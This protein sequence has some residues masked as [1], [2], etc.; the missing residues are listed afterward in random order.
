MGANNIAASLAY[1]LVVVRRHPDVDE[2]D[3]GASCNRTE[4]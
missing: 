4:G 1:A 2:I 3:L